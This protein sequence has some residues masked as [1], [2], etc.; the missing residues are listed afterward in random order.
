MNK[1]KAV[2]NSEALMNEIEVVDNSEELMNAIKLIQK[3]INSPPNI[4][5][6]R[7]PKKKKD[8]VP[9]EMYDKSYMVQSKYVEND[10]KKYDRI[11]HPYMLADSLH[12]ITSIGDL[13]FFMKFFIK[14]GENQIQ[15]FIISGKDIMAAFNQVSI[16]G[17]LAEIKS[18]LKIGGKIA[19]NNMRLLRARFNEFI[20]IHKNDILNSTLGDIRYFRK[21]IVKILRNK[22]VKELAWCS[23]HSSILFLEFIEFLL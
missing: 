13:I 5:P 17:F 23:I 2:D 3:S 12:G 18:Q 8:L 15:R 16:P 7:P 4:A 19:R 22:D 21:K 6:P 14:P 11:V 9:V 1:S 20:R 10:G